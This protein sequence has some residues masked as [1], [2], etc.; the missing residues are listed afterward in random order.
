MIYGGKEIKVLVV[1]PTVKDAVKAYLTKLDP[2]NEAISVNELEYGIDE[3]NS[4]CE[5]LDAKPLLGRKATIIGLIDELA[6][7]YDIV[8]LI[9]HAVP[10]GWFL[11]DGL[12]DASETTSLIRSTGAFLTVMN[13]CSS[14][15]VAKAAAKELGTAF[16]CTVKRVPDR[17]AFITSVLFAQKLAAGYDYATAYELAKP[18]QNSTYELIK[19]RKPMPPRD[20]SKPVYT[21]PSQNSI[22]PEVMMQFVKTVQDMDIIVNGSTRLGLPGFRASVSSMEA[23]LKMIAKDIAEMKSRQAFRNWWL[24]GYG[25][26]IILL[27]ASEALILFLVITK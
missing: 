1:F 11:G 6:V 22:D 18:G 2:K 4:L 20:P 16:I 8:W 13:T 9:T 14:I 5:L 12:V 3:V 23:E 19:S 26:A 15:D 17:K 25:L 24:W 21:E 27:M 10:E 7:G